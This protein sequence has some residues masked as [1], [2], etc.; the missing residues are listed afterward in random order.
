MTDKENDIRWRKYFY[1]GTNIL[2][3]NLKI[4]NSE[5]LKEVEATMSFDRLLELQD[6]PIKGNL[7]K[8]HLREVHKYLFE[9]VYPF[10]GQ[11]RIV[12]LIKKEGTFLHIDNSTDIDK[13]LDELFDEMNKLSMQCKS[14]HDLADLLSKLYTQLIYCHPFRE[15][16]GRSIREFVR[17]YSII[18]SSELE[19]ENVEL[20]WTKVDKK[21]LNENIAFAHLFPSNTAIIF[22]KAL[23]PV[24][25]NTKK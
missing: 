17:E 11:Y 23:V 5:T 21:E 16:N 6:N 3:N 12:N 20:D 22:E 15:G 25:V 8:K 10:A 19:I 2:I 7:D 9:D 24:D 18:K 1:P 14:K 4:K 13:Y